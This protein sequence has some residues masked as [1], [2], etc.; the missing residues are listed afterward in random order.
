MTSSLSYGSMDT[1]FGKVGHEHPVAMEHIIGGKSRSAGQFQTPSRH[2]P[3]SLVREIVKT[4]NPKK[5]TSVRRVVE[6][7]SKPLHAKRASKG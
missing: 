1:L 2:F 6:T 4:S 5:R 7:K 3:N